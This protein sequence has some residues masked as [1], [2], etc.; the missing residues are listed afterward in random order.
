MDTESVEENGW[1]S[2]VEIEERSETICE[3]GDKSEII[4]EIEDKS[5]IIGEFEDKSETIGEIEENSE[6]IGEIK[7]K[8]ETICEI[9]DKSENIVEIGDKS[10]IIV[11]IKDKSETIGEIENKSETIGE[12]EGKSENI[13]E[14]EVKSEI[15]GEIEVKPV[16]I[17]EIE[18]KFEPIG[19]IGDKSEA[20][21]EIEGKAES[22]VDI[23]DKSEIIV[24]IEVKPET[25]SEIEDKFEP[26]GEIR[27]T[28]ENIEEIE[29]KSENIIEDIIID[30]IKDSVDQLE[31]VDDE[32]DNA[33][34]NAVECVDVVF[35]YLDT[36]DHEGKNQELL[37]ENQ[38][39]CNQIADAQDTLNII[40]RSIV[41]SKEDDL[42]KVPSGEVYIYESDYNEEDSN[43]QKV[44]Q[45]E[46]VDFIDINAVQKD[47]EELL[48]EVSP[49]PDVF[50][51]KNIEYLKEDNIDKLKST[52]TNSNKDV[53]CIEG[54]KDE[55]QLMEDSKNLDITD[56]EK[57]STTYS[58]L[59]L[60]DDVEKTC[61]VT[62]VDINLD[63]ML[64]E[65]LSSNE[66]S[67][68][69]NLENFACDKND[70]NPIEALDKKE[71]ELIDDN[72]VDIKEE[73]SLKEDIVPHVYEDVEKVYQDTVEC[74][75]D[76]KPS[77][78]LYTIECGSNDDIKN[79]ACDAN[80]EAELIDDNDVE[81]LIGEFNDLSVNDV[82]G[83]DFDESF[84]DEIDV[85]LEADE[86]RFNMADNLLIDN[87]PGCDASIPQE[88]KNLHE[89]PTTGKHCRTNKVQNLQHVDDSQ[90]LQIKLLLNECKGIK[91]YI[92]EINTSYKCILNTKQCKCSKINES[93]TKCCSDA[94]SREVET[95]RTITNNTIHILEHNDQEEFAS[96]QDNNTP[97]IKTKHL[98]RSPYTKRKEIK[99]LFENHKDCE[100]SDILQE[101]INP[102][103][104][105]NK[106]ESSHQLKSSLT[107]TYFNDNEQSVDNIDNIINTEKISDMKKRRIV[108]IDEFE[109]D[110]ENTE[111]SDWV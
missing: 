65:E 41:G 102:Y 99:T 60:D 89:I 11:E 50:T 67:S 101:I 63:E 55:V 17:G 6:T 2:I 79:L 87:L 35:E 44:K 96:N 103:H 53:E 64:S 31:K 23:E 24:E 15:I 71:V 19:G 47:S 95:L 1:E 40:L 9:E 21:C 4:G 86:S 12:I 84:C 45:I 27:D 62:V 91:D 94:F 46:E 81:D 29:D 69:E 25:I 110:V 80:K 90:Q 104:G 78:D 77:E 32:I 42:N 20:I 43:L 73:D 52:E 109:D 7:D 39:V 56:I 108:V 98:M 106:P 82:I 83:Q 37:S 14:I 57:D 10:D 68:K 85:K 105:N 61:K 88:S 58:E 13:G 48:D 18:D 26:I 66:Y 51:P 5:E 33:L 36:E 30:I 22:I 28:A 16:T 8:S 93:C 72:V 54:D 111:E 74:A 75:C 97:V 34:D 3:I 92:E 76:K 70:A 100:T 38:V 59:N 49:D 107:R